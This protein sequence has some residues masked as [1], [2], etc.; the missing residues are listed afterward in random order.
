[1]CKNYKKMKD[2]IYEGPEIPTNV[3]TR[4]NLLMKMAYHSKYIE[5]VEM[6]GKHL[7]NDGYHAG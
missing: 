6:F 5:Y 3:S 1:M 7:S 4:K 2:G